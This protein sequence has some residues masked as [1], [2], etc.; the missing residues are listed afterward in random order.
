[1]HHALQKSDCMLVH[2][3]LTE[4]DC[5]SESGEFEPGFSHESSMNYSSSYFHDST[6][7]TNGVSVKSSMVHTIGEDITH[8]YVSDNDEYS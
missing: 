8:E 6:P 3:E 4:E 1:M 5:F 7:M 2:Q